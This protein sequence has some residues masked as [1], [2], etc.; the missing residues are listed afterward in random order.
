MI[1][2][3]KMIEKAVGILGGVGPLATVYFMEMIIRLTDAE[4]DQGH[5]NMVVLN[6]AT[7][8]D[9]TDFILGRSSENPLEIMV[10][11]AKKL[12]AAGA[13]FIVI[14]CNT[15]HYFY[16]SIRENVNIQMVSIIEETVE[17]AI[18]KIPALKKLGILATEGTIASKTYELEC[19]K[20]GIVCEI[21]NEEECAALMKI[22]Y[23]QVKA[24]KDIDIVAFMNIMNAM[25]KR[26]C[27]GIVL[28]CTELSVIRRE[29]KLLG[30]DVI[31]S[32]EALA[33]KTI[34]LGGK[35]ALKRC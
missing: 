35:K 34:R 23:E 6:H 32:L 21:P 20:H 9:R 31:D 27:D 13:D 29:Y 5:M 10:N 7:I 14:P 16:D 3:G 11:D 18:N 19:G 30:N 25:R 4:A 17:F 15:A 22:I 12:E 33:L 2:P 8:P 1:M 26:G 28:G 24:G